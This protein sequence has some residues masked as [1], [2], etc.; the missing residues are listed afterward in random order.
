M[1]KRK[2]Y[3]IFILATLIVCSNLN[4]FAHDSYDVEVA[5]FPIVKIP[6]T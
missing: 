6:I 1:L 4:V 3:F 2:L 5:K